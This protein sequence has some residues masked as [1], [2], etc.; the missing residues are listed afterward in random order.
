LSAGGSTIAVIGTP[1]NACYPAENQKLQEQIAAEHLVISQV[2]VHRYHH[3]DWR[4]HRMWFPARNKTM[5]ALTQATIIIE[6]GETSGTLIQARAALEQ[7]R[8]L[9]ILNS[10]FENP[11]LSWPHRLVNAGAVR[12]RTVADIIAM[13]KAP[14]GR[15]AFPD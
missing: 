1:L 10:C 8:Q 12:A 6:A 2:P 7:G 3:R 13:L 11:S 5:S 15:A 9:F 4:E 14:D